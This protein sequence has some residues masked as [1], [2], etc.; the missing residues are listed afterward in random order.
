MQ[1][2]MFYLFSDFGKITQTQVFKEVLDE[3]EYAEEL[4]FDSIWLP[5]HHFEVY[6]MLG[7]PLTFAAAVAQ[8]TKKMKI[9]TAV[10]VLPFQHPLRVAEDAAL[11][12]SLSDGRLLLGLGRGY[13]PPEFRGF[14]IPQENSSAMFAEGIEILKRALSGERFTYD[15]EY[16]KIEEPTEI[17]PK[18]IQTPHPPFYLASVTP[19][20]VEVA[21]RHG[22]SLLR[23]PQFSDL[24]TV[25]QAFETYKSK[26]REYGHDPDIIDQPLSVR[27]YVAPT[28]EEARAET[29]HLVWFYQ[30]LAKLLPGA[31]G[32]PMPPAGY[33]DYPRDPQVLG[34]ITE[35]QVWERGTCFGSPERV[36]EQMKRYMHALGST[37]FM[38][39]M[40]IGGL[41]HHKVRRSMEL[42]AKHV[43]P[44]LREEESKMNANV[45]APIIAD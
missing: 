43:M 11:V 18:P 15:G 27:V 17:F 4:G 13:Q 36:I 32:R 30:L 8:R 16:Y 7:N 25:S 2:G 35:D 33:E 28:D 26:M 21:A 29:K 39:Q 34:E 22:M 41:E 42:F 9:G 31:P 14:G 6:G 40:R 3:I 23:A 19:R 45:G 12:D 10:M 5:E 24:D 1:F 20:S 38:V 44:A 37:H